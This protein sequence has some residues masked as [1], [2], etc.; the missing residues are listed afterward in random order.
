MIRSLRGPAVLTLVLSLVSCADGA[1]ID[2]D[3]D[4]APINVWTDVRWPSTQIRVCWE[5]PTSD[6][7]ADRQW[8]KEAVEYWWNYRAGFGF[9]G[10]EPCAPGEAAVRVA[11]T[12]EPDDGN[13]SP[14]VRGFGRQLAGVASGVIIPHTY[15]N[16]WRTECRSAKRKQCQQEYAVHEFGHV[17]GFIHEQGR[18][19]T[20]AWCQE[21]DA[22]TGSF[23]T[24]GSPWDPESV[25][26]YCSS[27]RLGGG[28]LSG[29]DIY[30]SMVAYGTDAA[31]VYFFEHW[32]SD[33]RTGKKTGWYQGPGCHDV[34]GHHND[35]YSA[36]M[37]GRS[38]RGVRVY[39][40]VGC[41][42]PSEIFSVSSFLGRSWNDRVSSLEIQ[43]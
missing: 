11:V 42:G 26:G 31:K 43:Y 20:P 15:R 24:Y 6:N 3:A 28:Q 8:M 25:M 27:P 4:E 23:E 7:A 17:L 33:Y 37:L 9:H 30:Y 34:F 39:Q 38:V 21:G 19:D 22:R 2:L 40:D 35:I 12:D 14:H 5:N 13:T 16:H 32:S 41:R 18:D 1:D 29:L 36:V 10:W